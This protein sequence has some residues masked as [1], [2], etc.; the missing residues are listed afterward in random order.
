MYFKLC[1][2]LTFSFQLTWFEAREWCTERDMQLA[3][4]KTLSQVEAV[5]KELENRGLSKRA[6][7]Y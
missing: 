6:K 1:S 4:L 7:K 2:D 5:T 3:T